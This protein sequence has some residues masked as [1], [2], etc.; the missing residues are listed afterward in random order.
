VP[1]TNFRPP[2]AELRSVGRTTRNGRR[3]P[4]GHA[5]W[6]GSVGPRSRRRSGR[7]T[8]SASSGLSC[9]A[10]SASC[11]TSTSCGRAFSRRESSVSFSPAGTGRCIVLGLKGFRGKRVAGLEQ[12]RSVPADPFTSMDR[13]TQVS[14]DRWDERERSRSPYSSASSSRGMRG[15][16]RRGIW[17]RRGSTQGARH[18]SEVEPIQRNA[19]EQSR[20]RML[21]LEHLGNGPLE[22]RRGRLSLA[23]CGRSK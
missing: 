21:W 7:L 16:G 11:A 14:P 3:R 19:P 13:S 4:K 23:S 10:A 17:V 6:T 5:P 12:G 2:V 20:P 22:R 9:V 1:S 8:A 15:N 18:P